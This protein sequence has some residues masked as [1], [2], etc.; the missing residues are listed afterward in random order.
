MATAQFLYFAGMQNIQAGMVSLLVLIGHIGIHE[1]MS[2]IGFEMDDY[3][4]NML[5]QMDVANFMSFLLA[6]LGFG[7]VHVP[8]KIYELRLKYKP[9]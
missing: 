5:T 9:N 8:V 7:I 4:F 3:V 6:G 2:D 1:F